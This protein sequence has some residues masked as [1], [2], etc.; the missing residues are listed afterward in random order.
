VLLSAGGSVLPRQLAKILVTNVYIYIYIYI[1]IDIDIYVYV[2]IYVYMYI[3]CIYVYIM[4]IHI[5]IYN[6][7]INKSR[8]KKIEKSLS[9]VL[10]PSTTGYSPAP[11]R[12]VNFRPSAMLVV[13]VCTLATQL[14]S[15]W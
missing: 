9:R 7:Y 3:L 5:Y 1:D 4:Y 6:I 14:C 15:C 13:E 11:H 2:D 10:V 8:L 12:G